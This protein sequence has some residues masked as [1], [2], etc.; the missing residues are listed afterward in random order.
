M[1][2]EIVLWIKLYKNGVSLS[3]IC[4][5][6]RR[7]RKTVKKYLEL[8]GVEI[9]RAGMYKKKFDNNKIVLL[10]EGGESV[11]SIAKRFNTSRST[12][13]GRLHEM[14]VTLKHP[15]GNRSHQWKGGRRLWNGYYVIYRGPKE[16]EFE[17]R[18]IWEH[19]NG[20]IPD[21]YIVHHLNN[22]KTDNRIDNLIAMPK[23]HHSAK[24]VVDP[25]VKC[26]KELEEEIKKLKKRV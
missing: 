17:H 19:Y 24:T 6:F 12:I 20:K 15:T 1:E 21:G 8:N 25:Y 13:V 23:K 16:Y 14:G 2:N 9:K 11:S 3:K 5:K 26:I 7:A 22:I 18:M 4:K 10:Y